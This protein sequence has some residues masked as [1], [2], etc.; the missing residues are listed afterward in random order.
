MR[1]GYNVTFV[2]TGLMK[3]AQT[4]K[5]TLFFFYINVI[6]VKIKLTFDCFAILKNIVSGTTRH[7]SSCYENILV[8]VL[9]FPYHRIKL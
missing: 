1:T 7:I 6:F 5:E 3:T 4:Q 9:L 2:I 8:F